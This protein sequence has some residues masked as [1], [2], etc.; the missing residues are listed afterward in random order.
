MNDTTKELSDFTIILDGKGGGYLPEQEQTDKEK[1]PNTPNNFWQNLDYKD[2]EAYR[3]LTEDY[4]IESTVA[5]ALCDEETRPR[6][7][8]TEKGIVIILRDVNLNK[9]SDIDD[10]VSLRFWIDDKKII[11]LSHR[12]SKSIRLVFEKLLKKT[13]PKTA[14]ECFIDIADGIVSNIENVVMEIRDN[15]DD[16]EE[17]VINLDTLSDFDLRESL[18]ELR[19][20]IISIRRYSNPQ[21]DIFLNLQHETS[22][23]FK[24]HKNKARLRETYNTL[25]K[26]I[27][28]LDY[29]KDHLSVFYEE[30]Q[31][32]MSINMNR[33]MYMISIVTVIFMPLG[34][35]TGLLGINVAGIP[36]AEQHWA[37]AAVCGFL[38]LLVTVLLAIMRK[39]HWL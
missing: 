4:E 20:E 25:V 26:I 16:L 32:K 22:S 11:S 3:L 24:G 27:E 7:F 6:Y 17:R 35:I 23:V 18:S 1:F 33:I 12:K 28:D 38:F 30:L 34:L 8:A 36:Y 2:P 39:L 13:G 10:M 31:S 9:N 5:D 29:A 37:F 19:R 14:A 21:K 15:T